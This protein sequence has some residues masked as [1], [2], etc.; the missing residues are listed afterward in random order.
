MPYPCCCCIDDCTTLSDDRSTGI[1][2]DLDVSGVTNGTCSACNNWN[3]VW[4]IPGYAFTSP[5]ASG[6]YCGVARITTCVWED[7]FSN[8][9]PGTGFTC[10][11]NQS[12][13][14]W[15]LFLMELSGGGTA[16]LVD[17]GSERDG[18]P[19]ASGD[20]VWAEWIKVFPGKICFPTTIDSTHYKSSGTCRTLQ[21]TGVCDFSDAEIVINIA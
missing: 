17:I 15:R 11:N 21:S 6:T 18:A 10:Y 13:I 7:F 12:D 14:T 8:I 16:L 5:P 2:F 1:D 9:F 4:T 3:T 19:G 20:A